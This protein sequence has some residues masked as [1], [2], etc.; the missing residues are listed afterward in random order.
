M[1][2]TL[3]KRC[4]LS[5][6]KIT[7]LILV[8]YRKG[9]CQIHIRDLKQGRRPEVKMQLSVLLRMLHSSSTW[10]SELENAIFAVLAERQQSVRIKWCIFIL[11]TKIIYVWLLKWKV[12]YSLDS[13]PCTILHVTAIWNIK[14]LQTVKNS[15]S[16]GFA[17]CQQNI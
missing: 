16:V 10:S 3:N 6:S 11:F 17:S 7:Y 5:D 12:R 2:D 8:I 15:D 1:F 9:L 4:K 13:N 14:T